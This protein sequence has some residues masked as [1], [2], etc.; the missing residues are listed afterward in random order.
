[1]SAMARKVPDKR[2]SAYGGPRTESHVR[3]TPPIRRS[4]PDVA[5]DSDRG[6]RGPSTLPPPPFQNEAEV[7]G[8]E[9]W[10]EL[11]MELAAN[12]LCLRQRV[13]PVPPSFPSPTPAALTRVGAVSEALAKVRDALY[14][15]YC[16]AA[17]PRMRASTASDAPLAAYVAGLYRFCGQVVE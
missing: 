6:S 7:A 5:A 12:L 15:V 10:L 4:D 1:G 17:D 3:F 11:H 16:A 2:P 9:W 13:D 14:E 8:N